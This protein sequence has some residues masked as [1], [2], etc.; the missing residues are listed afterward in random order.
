MSQTINDQ[1]LA[2]WAN[3]R[4]G[5]VALHLRRELLPVEGE[6]GVFFPPTYADAKDGYNIDVLS[7]GTKV[8]LVDSVGA[9][10][11]RLE[12]LFCEAELEH[13]VPQIDIA[14][15]AADKVKKTLSLLKVG[16]RL[17]DAAVRST[18][19]KDEAQAAFRA[20]LAGDAMPIARLNPTALIFGAWDSRDTMAK[21]PR[22]LQSTIRAWDVE[23]LQ[24]SA[25]YTPSLP[26][27]ELETFSEEQRKKAEGNNKSPLA[28]RGFVD[29]PAGQTHGGVTA[30][31]PIVQD[32]T[33]N[34]VALRRLEANDHTALL[35][36]YILGLA[37]VAGTQYADPFL[38]QGCLLVPKAPQDLWALVER[39]GTRTEID[40]HADLALEFATE[41]AKR[42]EVPRDRRTVEFDKK[43]AKA[44]LKK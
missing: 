27:A 13:L 15:V 34:L 20:L 14:Y 41:R 26:Y 24:R 39:N 23:Q 31:G 2:R 21:V 32:I 30:N 5:P 36:E 28:Q 25:Q 43:L 19:L 7:D 29:V 10:A 16:H 3:D 42:F 44:D 12:P 11:N 17:G 8:A 37:L 33:I 4:T 6:G 1:E 40:L 18:A 35:H 38:R 22:I 9:Q